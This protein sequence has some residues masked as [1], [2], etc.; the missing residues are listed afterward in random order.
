MTNLI[1]TFDSLKQ[2]YLRYFDSPFDLRFQELVL[3]R[4]RMLDRDGVLYREPL[5][6]PQPPYAGSRQNVRSVT[7]SVL[8][9][10]AHWPERSI[11]DLAGIAEAGLF[12][13]RA[14]ISVELYAH[15]V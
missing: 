13:P 15:Q 10:S 9:A 1:Q 5:I 3:A 12:A 11:V 4:R 2:S 6:E 8:A 7:T 14:G